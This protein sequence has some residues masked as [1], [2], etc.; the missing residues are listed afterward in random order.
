MKIIAFFDLQEQ[1]AP[2]S[3]HQWVQER[4]IPAFRKYLPQMS[5]FRVLAVVETDNC[6]HAR[7]VVQ[8]FEWNASADDWRL[9][10]KSF[11][12]PK[13]QELYALSQEWLSMCV[14]ESTQILYAESMAR[15][16]GSCARRSYS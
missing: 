16:E 14:D 12:L 9:A 1:T 10:L 6:A 8:V 13:N 15:P 7:Q 5:D 3:F 2:R 11:R 4:Q